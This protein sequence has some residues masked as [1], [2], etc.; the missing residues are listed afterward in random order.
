M[1]QQQLLR[2]TPNEMTLVCGQSRP[3]I[4]SP[5]MSLERIQLSIESILC[6]ESS[7][8]EGDLNATISGSVTVTL[9]CRISKTLSTMSFFT[10]SLRMKVELPIQDRHTSLD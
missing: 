2:K 6:P 1:L 3:G 7:Y 10:S 4:I 9:G 8:G 5:A